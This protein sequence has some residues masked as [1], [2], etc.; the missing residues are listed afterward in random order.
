MYFKFCCFQIRYPKLEN[1]AKWGHIIKSN[2]KNVLSF[3]YETK[4]CPNSS[5]SLCVILFTDKSQSAQIDY[6][7]EGKPSKNIM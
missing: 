2:K 5:F 7:R 6:K 4:G 1:V 3:R